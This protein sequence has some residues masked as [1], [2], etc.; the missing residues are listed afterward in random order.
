M[1]VVG[2][3][4]SDTPPAA[5]IASDADRLSSASQPLQFS[6]TGFQKSS[7]TGTLVAL[8]LNL[9]HYMSLV[10]DKFLEG[11]NNQC[12]SQSISTRK[13]IWRPP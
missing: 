6:H 4:K 9:P 13:S 5:E 7:S 8:P 12:R 2:Q 3:R 10:V 11:E 1:S